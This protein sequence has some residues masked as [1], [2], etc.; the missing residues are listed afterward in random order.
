M[1]SIIEKNRWKVKLTVDEQN[2]L[3]TRYNK[4]LALH[5]SENKIQLS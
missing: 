2:L 5:L 4:G 1:L 3:A